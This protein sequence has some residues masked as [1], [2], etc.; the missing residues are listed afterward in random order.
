MS[1]PHIPPI[2]KTVPQNSSVSRYGEFFR[3]SVRS[4]TSLSACPSPPSNQPSSGM[5]FRPGSTRN[6]TAQPATLSNSQAVPYPHRPQT[7]YPP[8]SPD[9]AAAKASAFRTTLFLI[10][11]HTYFAIA[12]SNSFRIILR[13][14]SRMPSVIFSGSTVPLISLP[15]PRT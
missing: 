11:C 3:Y 8:R 6:R 15:S 4:S 13:I 10:T 12:F 14:T 5:P 1:I 2:K 9:Q 7:P